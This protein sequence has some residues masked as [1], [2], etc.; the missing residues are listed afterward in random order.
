MNHKDLQNHPLG[1]QFIQSQKDHL[2]SHDQKGTWKEVSTNDPDADGCEILDSRWVFAYKFD[3]HGILQKVKA[4]LVVRGDQQSRTSDEN[5]YAATLAGRS[6]RTVMAIAAK[7]DLELIQYDAVNAFVNVRLDEKVFMR[8][9]PGYRKRGVILRLK[10]ALYGLRRSPLLWQRD[11]T[12]ILLDIGYKPVPHEPCA[13]LRNGIIV[14]FYVD[15]IVIAY[16]KEKQ[17]EARETIRQLKQ[18]YELQGGND[19]HWFLGI[20]VI[21]DRSKR[22][23]W[24]TQTSYIDKTSNLALE[25]HHGWTPMKQEE[26]L[27]FN[28]TAKLQDVRAY[29]RKIGS[30]MYIAVQTRP[31]I[32]FAVSKLARFMTNPGPQHHSAADRVLNYLEQ[33]K[34]LGL[35]FGGDKDLR[36][37]SDASFADNKLDRKSSQGY[38]IK[39]F[40]GMIGWRANKQNTVTTS[41]TEAE[42]LAL[43]QAAK[44]SM[45]VSCLLKE[46]TVKLDD[47][48]IRI[49]CDNQQTIGIVTKENLALRSNLRHVDIHNH[50]L[51]QEYQRGQIDV[52]YTQ[53]S[54]MIADGLTKALPRQSFEKFRAEMGL[55]DIQERIR[56]NT[57]EESNDVNI[58][59]NF[60]TTD[61]E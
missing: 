8:P 3:K 56:E 7:F 16:R 34:S 31:D 42:L 49:E 14:F 23:I 20:Q 38:A 43:A 19:L 24:L 21:R 57:A 1:P 18:K 46:L 13:F 5:N 44:E 39:L 37:A 28:E 59:D 6:F 54:N 52:V 17:S 50:W 11:L 26:L 40:G 47:E 48:R 45:F 36:V 53:S 51:R 32:A 9:P 58:D 29:Q 10:K 22:R 12:S 27:P 60:W 41:T 2:G 55:E 33:S 15:D 35:K 30:L 25:R 4:R 61:A